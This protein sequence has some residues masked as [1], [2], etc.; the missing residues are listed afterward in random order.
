VR[1][2]ALVHFYVPQYMAGSETMLH[3]MLRALVERGHEAEVVVTSHERGPAEYEHEGIRVRCAGRRTVVELLD[4]IAPDV[5]VSHHQEAPNACHYARPR[6]V[7]SV[8][9]FHNTFPGAL[10]VA[11]R[12]RPDLHV[13]NTHWVADYY[14]RRKA[15]PAGSIVVH[16]PIDG[17]RHRTRPGTHVTLVNLNKDK[18]GEI[19]YRLTERMPDVGFL[20]VVGGHGEQIIRTGLPNVAIQPHTADP[21][22]DVWA[23]TRILLM[24]SVYESYGMVAIEAAH[25][26]IPTIAAPTPGLREALGSA[27][28]WAVRRKLDAWEAEIRRLLQPAAWRTASAAAHARAAELDPREE[29]AAWV[30][31]IESL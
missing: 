13:F 7:K 8:V 3:A 11:R 26:G 4:G 5:V 30:D 16:P 2:A 24:P 12:W 17:S 14:R 18:G 28:T 27:G 29:L 23:R 25:C 22:R 31:A 1:V 10:Q 15:A 20:G 21:R 19:F 9:L 6:G